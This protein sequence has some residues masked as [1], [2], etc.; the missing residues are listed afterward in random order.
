MFL[1]HIFLLA[2]LQQENI[3]QRSSGG[4][5][6]VKSLLSVYFVVFVFFFVLLWSKRLS[7]PPT[8]LSRRTPLRHGQ[9]SRINLRLNLSQRTVQEPSDG[10]PGACDAGAPRQPAAIIATA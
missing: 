9:I 5:A 8:Q 10:K 6:G 1:V 2:K 7:L 3:D 4:I